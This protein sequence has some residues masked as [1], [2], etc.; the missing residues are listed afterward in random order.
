M[1]SAKTKFLRNKKPKMNSSVISNFLSP[2]FC[3]KF[4]HE[5]LNRNETEED[6][7]PSQCRGTQLYPQYNQDK[8][9]LA[10]TNPKVV[11]EHHCLHK[12]SRINMFTQQCIKLY[13]YN[14]IYQTFLHTRVLIYIYISLE[15]ARL[16]ESHHKNAKFRV[17]LPIVLLTY[18]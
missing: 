5:A 3:E 11:D 6:C 16:I 7:K 14:Y 2:E 12:V 13:I 15:T 17:Y 4:S 1:S 10:G 9:R 8:Y 18:S